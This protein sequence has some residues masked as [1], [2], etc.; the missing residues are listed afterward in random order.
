MLTLPAGTRNKQR[1][2]IDGD[3]AGHGDETEQEAQTYF[4]LRDVTAQV[5][6]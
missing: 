3:V 5:E 6:S 4:S 2:L 1:R